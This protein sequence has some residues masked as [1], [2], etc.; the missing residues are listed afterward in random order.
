MNLSLKNKLLFTKEHRFSW[1]L[2]T[3]HDILAMIKDNCLNN[4]DIC[5]KQV[6]F[7][8]IRLSQHAKTKNM[9]FSLKNNILFSKIHRLSCLSPTNHDIL[10]MI[11]NNTLQTR[12]ILSKLVAFDSIHLTL[13][14][15]NKNVYLLLK[16]NL[17]SQRNLVIVL[18]AYGTRYFRYDR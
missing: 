18:L 7:E 5:F 15:N 17:Y 6:V 12:D 16:N 10:D 13:P 1:L 14:V 8:R 3:E 9:Y 11:D 2:L 4:Q